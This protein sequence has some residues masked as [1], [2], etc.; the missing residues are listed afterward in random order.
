MF[1]TFSTVLYFGTNLSSPSTSQYP[2][3]EVFSKP[4]AWLD[5]PASTLHDRCN[6]LFC[7]GNFNATSA[8]FSLNSLMSF[9]NHKTLFSS[10]FLVI[11]FVSSAWICLVFLLAS[12]QIYV[13][14]LEELES[15]FF[16]QDP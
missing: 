2:T 13:P 11:I 10:V 5:I 1:L 12:L 16:K 15:R 9:Y 7:L 4:G 3:K 8:F 6:K 14:F